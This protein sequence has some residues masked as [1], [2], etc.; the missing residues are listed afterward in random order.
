MTKNRSFQKV[1]RQGK[2]KE[3]RINLGI[4]F[5]LIVALI[6]ALVTRGAFV[7]KED[8]SVN[9]LDADKAQIESI[10]DSALAGQRGCVVTGR[11]YSRIGTSKTADPKYPSTITPLV[12]E[13]IT[14]RDS[15]NF[16]RVAT[17]KSVKDGYYILGLS[18][19]LNPNAKYLVDIEAK[20]GLLPVSSET[21]TINCTSPKPA[22]GKP[23]DNKKVVDFPL[24][25]TIYGYAWNDSNGDSIKQPTEKRVYGVEL[26]LT[27]CNSKEKPMVAVTSADIVYPLGD[28][29][30]FFA[31]NSPGCFVV[32]AKLPKGAVDKLAEAMVEFSDK[33]VQVNFPIVKNVISAP[34]VISGTLRIPT[35][36]LQQLSPKLPDVTIPKMEINLPPKI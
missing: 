29:D 3:K 13:R 11:V 4:F 7:K 35:L 27:K 21:T 2:P 22:P 5:I 14:L 33:S 24:A 25:R 34:I 18:K 28:T 32:K 6:L 1:K 20:E 26:S 30:Y 23:V 31:P 36:R 19:G 16:K 10:A 15:V 12:G 8:I 17:T 9:Y